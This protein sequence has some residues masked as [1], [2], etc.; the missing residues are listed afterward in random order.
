LSGAPLPDRAISAL[1]FGLNALYGANLNNNGDRT[2]YLVTIDPSTGN[3]TNLGQSV[4]GLTALAF[5]PAAAI[6]PAPTPAATPRRANFPTTSGAFQRE[7]VTPGT[8]D[9]FVTK[10]NAAGTAFVYST[11]LGGSEEEVAWSI[12]VGADGSA[13]VAGYTDSTAATETPS[14]SPSPAAQGFP[15][16]TNAYQQQNAG[17]YDAF[18]TRVNPTG[19]AL[20]YSTYLGGDRN[21]GEGG[22]ECLEC[23]VRYD[24]AAVA[25]DF[26][27]NAYITGWTESTFVAPTPEP[28]LHPRRPAR[29]R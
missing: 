2:A 23:A 25:V 8:R 4:N 24:G 17:G 14:P 9:A 10:V 27:G 7:P 21:E 26:V 1:S 6:S 15:T 18:L 29:R 28:S 5:A 20:L 11:F 12:A 13:F 16:T 3:V 22:G 19:S